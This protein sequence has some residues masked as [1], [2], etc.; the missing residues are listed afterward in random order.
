MTHP[1]WEW[2]KLNAM[3]LASCFY[4]VKV[5]HVL[6]ARIP[7]KNH[8]LKTN[9]A[10]NCW[11]SSQTETEYNSIFSN[12]PKC[13]TI[14]YFIFVLFLFGFPFKGEQSLM[15]C[16]PPTRPYSCSGVERVH[17]IITIIRFFCSYKHDK[18]VV[19][20]VVNFGTCLALLLFAIHCQVLTLS[21]F[22][23]IKYE[24]TFCEDL[25]CQ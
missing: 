19:P 4:G 6:S 5:S 9:C 13:G 22:F 2:S 1:K 17:L 3:T 20:Q 8:V 15:M 16:R 21:W 10:C 12:H 18:I 23:G 25:S 11:L 24:Y 14:K 7:L